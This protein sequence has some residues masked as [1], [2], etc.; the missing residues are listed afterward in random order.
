MGLDRLTKKMVCSLHQ[1]SHSPYAKQWNRYLCFLR[2]FWIMWERN[3]VKY[4]LH[5]TQPENLLVHH[6]PLTI[7]SWRWNTSE[8]RTRQEMGFSIINKARKDVWEA[9]KLINKKLARIL[10]RDKFK[11][12]NSFGVLVESLS[13]NWIRGCNLEVLGAIIIGVGSTLYNAFEKSIN[14]GS[15]ALLMEQD[16]VKELWQRLETTTVIK[17]RS[18]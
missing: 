18:D 10:T 7:Q 5:P 15:F 1:R 4:E 17:L 11:T 13:E 2:L 16:A 6:F 12:G 9:Q 3:L 14:F 8:S